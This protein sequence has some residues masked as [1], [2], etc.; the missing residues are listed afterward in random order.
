MSTSAWNRATS[1]STPR[2]SASAY[3]L[4]RVAAACALS[5]EAFDARYSF[6]IFSNCAC[7]IAP[8]LMSFSARSRTSFAAAST[9]RADYSCFEA[10]L[11]TALSCALACTASTRLASLAFTAFSKGS[12][13]IRN[14]TSPVLSGVFGRATTSITR[15]LTLGTMGV[16]LN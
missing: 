13:S 1:V 12:G 7:A 11:A 15:P 4:A 6:L 8:D 5:A 3:R 9:A 14:R 2:I 10:L 16:V